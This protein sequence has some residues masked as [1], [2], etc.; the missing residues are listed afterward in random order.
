[1]PVPIASGTI[2]SDTCLNPEVV[3]TVEVQ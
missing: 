3:Q 2:V 1:V